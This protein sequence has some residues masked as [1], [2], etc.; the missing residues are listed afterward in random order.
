MPL[1]M[2]TAPMACERFLRVSPVVRLP[3]RRNG[4]GLRTAVTDSLPTARTM[5]PQTYDVS[6]PV[7]LVPRPAITR[8]LPICRPSST[9]ARAIAR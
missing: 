4:V 3:V 5:P 6:V 1:V 8:D 7:R 2:D 9:P